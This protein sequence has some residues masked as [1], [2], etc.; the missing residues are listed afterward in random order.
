MEWLNLDLT[1]GITNEA[2]GSRVQ[3]QFIPLKTSH[4]GVYTCQATVGDKIF[5]KNYTL[6]VKR[7]LKFNV[8]IN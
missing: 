2:N 4:G 7:K 1:S 6:D 3:L 5:T 8:Y